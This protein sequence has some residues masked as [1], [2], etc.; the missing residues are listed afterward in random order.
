LRDRRQ[1]TEELQADC[2]QRLALQK[3]EFKSLTEKNM[4]FLQSLLKDKEEFL[5]NRAKGLED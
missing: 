4:E 5:K 3:R 2:E 1:S